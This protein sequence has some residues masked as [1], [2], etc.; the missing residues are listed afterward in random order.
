MKLSNKGSMF[1]VDNSNK[2]WLLKLNNL[3]EFESRN[4]MSYK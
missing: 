4:P 1:K 2:V 3:I